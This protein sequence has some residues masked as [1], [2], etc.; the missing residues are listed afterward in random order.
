MRHLNYD[1]GRMPALHE[2]PQII[3]MKNRATEG[4]TCESCGEQ[5]IQQTGTS[6]K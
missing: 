1:I 6:T 2:L 3:G 5:R 4:D